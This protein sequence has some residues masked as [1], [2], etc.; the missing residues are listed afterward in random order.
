MKC[1]A[2]RSFQ[3]NQL[4][5]NS[6][7]L[8]YEVTR[9][10]LSILYI[11]CIFY[12]TINTRKDNFIN[13]AKCVEAS[14]PNFLRFCPNFYNSKFLGV[15]LC[16]RILYRC[17]PIHFLNIPLITYNMEDK[18]SPPSKSRNWR[19]LVSHFNRE[20]LLYVD[21]SFLLIDRNNII[22]MILKKN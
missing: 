4:L 15:R 1:L 16:L 11:K 18:L 21:K 9:N 8:K 6:H 2:L 5:I 13:I 17:T 10:S 3:G 19:S 7:K 20:S 12:D 22:F 14:L